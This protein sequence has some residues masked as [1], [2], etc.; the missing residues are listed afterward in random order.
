[1]G[2]DDR[3]KRVIAFGEVSNQELQIILVDATAELEKRHK[4]YRVLR[5]P[6]YESQRELE[7]LQDQA[8]TGYA[9]S[10][11]ERS[12]IERE[13]KQSIPADQSTTAKRVAYIKNDIVRFWYMLLTRDGDHLGI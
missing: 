2:T 10:E 6:C 9:D 4:P 13:Y 3:L 1:M 11:T 5:P 7:I 12:G 8:E